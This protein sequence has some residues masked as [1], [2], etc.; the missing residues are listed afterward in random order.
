MNEFPPLERWFD[1]KSQS[2]DRH[3]YVRYDLCLKSNLTVE[4]LDSF[5]DELS[6]VIARL[7]LGSQEYSEWRNYWDNAELVPHSKRM[8]FQDAF[9]TGFVNKE[10]GDNKT[11]LQGYIGELIL[12]LIQEQQY[13]QKIDASPR[14]PKNLPSVGG[15]DC[16]EICGDPSNESTLHYIVWEC[17]ATT[18]DDPG[19][20][21]SKI[22]SQ[23]LN[24]T[25][26][27]FREMIS[28]FED[29]HT[30]DPILSKFVSEMIADFYANPPTTKKRF[31]G[32]VTLN[33]NTMVSPNA[34]AKFYRK[35]EGKLADDNRCRQ[36]RFCSIGDIEFIA[37]EVRKK[38]WSKLRP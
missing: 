30:D 16:L 17:K 11:G 19:G 18:S 27:S 12:Y 15:I 7:R 4:E 36:V 24:D 14:R 6:L 20:Y 26:K 34:Y 25:A 35:F 38:I 32:C 31:G 5:T 23:H 9:S 13:P 33:A 21:P 22:Y 29:V 2:S 37:E 8:Q 28:F 3:K 10:G 1:I